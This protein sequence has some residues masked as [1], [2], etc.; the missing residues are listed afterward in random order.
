[1][2]HRSPL[3]RSMKHHHPAKYIEPKPLNRVMNRPNPRLHLCSPPATAPASLWGCLAAIICSEARGG[4]NSPSPFPQA[5]PLNIE[6][7]S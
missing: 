4:K 1:M 7:D 5:F 6:S 2:I 3:S